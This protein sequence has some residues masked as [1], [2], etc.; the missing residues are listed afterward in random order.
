MPS[1]I[2][3]SGTQQ[4]LQQFVQIL[5]NELDHKLASFKRK[6]D[7]KEDLHASQLKKFKL[8][9]K[10]TSSLKFK[11][12][13]IQLQYD[14]NAVSIN[15]VSRKFRNTSWTVTCPIANAELEKQLN[16]INSI[17]KQAHR[18]DFSGQISV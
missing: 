8:E 5:D 18:L 16:I 7:K 6:F 13:K 1:A 14:F 11:G 15:I 2:D 17:K 9:S 4:L 3:P 10:A 12:N